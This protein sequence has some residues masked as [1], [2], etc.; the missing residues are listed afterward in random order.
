M[1]LAHP[2]QVQGPQALPA[3]LQG[4][5]GRQWVGGESAAAGLPAPGSA[6]AGFTRSEYRR[7][8]G[9]ITYIEVGDMPHPSNSIAAQE[10]ARNPPVQ[11]DL[12][13]LFLHQGKENTAQE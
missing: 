9:D 8:A 5:Q 2:A 3:V 1:Q 4:K 6:A 13:S 11:A 12:L 10:M 7:C